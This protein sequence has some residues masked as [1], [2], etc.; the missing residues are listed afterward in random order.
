MLRRHAAPGPLPPPDPRRPGLSTAGSRYVDRHG[1]AAQPLRMTGALD[2]LLLR[3]DGV[4]ARW[5]V[6]AAGRD[7]NWIENRVRRREW[8]RVHRGVYVNHTG[9]PT[10]TQRAWAAVL[11]YWP[12]A[13]CGR[14]A[15][16]VAFRGPSSGRPIPDG[17][18]IEVAV[19]GERHV[20]RIPGIDVS[21]VKGLATHLQP[22]RIPPRVRLE[23]ALVHAASSAR[24]D[25]DALAMLAD[26]CQQGRTTPSRLVRALLIEPRLPRRRF[27]LQVLEDVAD[28]VYSVLEH[29]YLH[30]VERPHGLPTARRQRRIRPGRVAA[31]RDVEY[32]GTGAVVE[33]D[34]RLGHELAFDR[35]SD[36]E[37][38]VESV[39]A[40]DVTVRLTW[41]QVLEPCRS[42]DLVARLLR[43][44]GWTGRL[45]ACG[46]SC[47]VRPSRDNGAF[48]APEAEN[49][50]S[51]LRGPA[52]RSA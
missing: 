42:A 22:N 29:R 34:G 16:Q 9:A 49:A 38:D 30:Q 11:F 5:Q 50:P 45:Q 8:A 15:V 14:S 17:L 32:L 21:R 39:L 52:R 40:G 24:S 20:R 12:A 19:D 23:H 7:D 31:Y 44:R 48:P 18:P 46:P 35:W 2:Q 4:I 6:L 36:A 10:W 3:Q 25:A 33:L 27:L 1:R 26:A 51:S 28:G 37:R 41:G 47:A 13:L 43:A